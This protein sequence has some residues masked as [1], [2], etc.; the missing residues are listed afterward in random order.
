[1]LQCN[2]NRQPDQEWN[3]ST[4]HWGTGRDIFSG[5]IFGLFSISA[6]NRNC[7]F[8][9]KLFAGRNFQLLKYL[10]A[11]FP[12]SKFTLKFIKSSHLCDVIL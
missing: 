4:E 8:R 5:H 12:S 1:M 9:P 7:H 2:D 11:K 3:L 10:I 6:K